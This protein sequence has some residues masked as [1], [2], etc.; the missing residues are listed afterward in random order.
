MNDDG[1]I[2]EMGLCQHVR[3]KVEGLRYFFELFALLLL[4]CMTADCTYIHLRFY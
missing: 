4:R 3:Q 1:H 2:D